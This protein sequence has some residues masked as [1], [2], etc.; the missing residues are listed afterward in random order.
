MSATAEPRPDFAPRAL[1]FLAAMAAVAALYWAREILLPLALATLGAFLLAPAVRQAE[2]LRIGRGGAV[3]LASFGVVALTGALGWVFVRQAGGV[4]AQLPAHREKIIDRIRAIRSALPST[5]TTSV[6]VAEISKEIVGRPASAPASQPGL[7][8]LMGPPSGLITDDESVFE[9]AQ[10]APVKVELVPPTPDIGDFFGSTIA[11]IVNP[12]LTVAMA[13]LLSMFFLTYRED[14]RDRIVRICGRAHINVTTA[15]LTDVAARITRYML[16]QSV[17]N[18]LCGTTIGVGLF[19]LGVPQAFAWGLLTGILR[20][21]PFLGPAAAAALTALHSLATSESAFQPLFVLGYFLLVDA[22]IGNLFEPWYFG[23]RVGASPTAIL[24][25]ILFWGWLWGA[26]GVLLATPLLVCLVVLGKHVQGFENLYILLSDEPVLEPKMRLYQRLLAN[27][28][29]EALAIVGRAAEEGSPQAALGDIL[30]PALAQLELDR[31]HQMIEPE[32]IEAA[33]ETARAAIDAHLPPS[34]TADEAPQSSSDASAHVICAVGAGAFDDC[35]A[36]IVER[37]L[38]ADN[39]RFTKFSN[40]AFA[41]EIA[42]KVSSEQ[43]EAVLLAVVGPRDLQ[44]TDLLSRR[45][46]AGSASSILIGLIQ[47]PGRYWRADLAHRSGRTIVSEGFPQILS[48][49]R[50]LLRV[51]PPAAIVSSDQG[52]SARAEE[53]A[54]IGLEIV[55]PSQM[56]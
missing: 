26:L 17:S 30:L 50:R 15:A 51:F 18:A 42:Q 35:L 19:L 14:I 48:E 28:Q 10:S 25:A 4:V 8:E 53:S 20:F 31:Q 12:L 1:A 33:R 34:P 47:S 9:T 27:D 22:S 46:R 21:V 43:P 16:A 45:I 3:L 55:Q 36:E 11:R 49:L 29:A 56:A 5:G 7:G 40:A 23:S 32:R 37:S 13:A 24:I 6:A 39:V 52:R 54:V 2:R 44:R 41:S 38:R